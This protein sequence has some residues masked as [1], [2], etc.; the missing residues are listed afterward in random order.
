MIYAYNV[1]VSLSNGVHVLNYFDSVVEALTWAAKQLRLKIVAI[2][3]EVEI[4]I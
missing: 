4:S 3:N 1:E 2:P